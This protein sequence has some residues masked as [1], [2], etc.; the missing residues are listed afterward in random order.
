MQH[1][2]IV[3]S[4]LKANWFL[5]ISIWIWNVQKNPVD[6]NKLRQAA[7]F[8]WG[9]DNRSWYYQYD[10]SWDWDCK[11]SWKVRRISTQTFL[12]RSLFC[13]SCFIISL[14]ENYDMWDCRVTQRVMDWV[15]FEPT[16]LHLRST[17]STTEL[18]ALRSL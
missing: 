12:K 5:Q 15:G 6:I 9:F 16:T 3:G 13:D 2:S 8:K 1:Y 14:R 11:G 7:F 10:L 17:H 18:P 4:I